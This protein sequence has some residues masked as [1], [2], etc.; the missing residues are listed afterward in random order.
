M[1]KTQTPRKNGGGSFSSQMA[2]I[3]IPSDDEALEIKREYMENGYSHN[4]K[5][6]N[7]FSM[8]ADEADD[9]GAQYYEPNAYDLEGDMV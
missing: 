6:G 1:T 8:D 4:N 9:D 7:S 5:N 2:P 3:S